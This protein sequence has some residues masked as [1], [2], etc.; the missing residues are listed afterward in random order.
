MDLYAIGKPEGRL[1]T[2]SGMENWRKEEARL[3]FV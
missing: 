2:R 3:T 1:G